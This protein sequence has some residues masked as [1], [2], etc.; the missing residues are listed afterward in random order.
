MSK[1]KVCERCG[2]KW[3]WGD[4]P[5]TRNVHTDYAHTCYECHL[6]LLEE[7]NDDRSEVG[8][9]DEAE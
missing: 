6:D 3:H 1:R 7:E 8:E 4:L 5:W 2:K 9:G